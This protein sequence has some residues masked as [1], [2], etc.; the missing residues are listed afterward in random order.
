MQACFVILF[1]LYQLH[2]PWEHPLFIHHLESNVILPAIIQEKG[3]NEVESIGR[4]F[5]LERGQL[6]PLASGG[7]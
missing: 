4:V 7:R 2:E 3:N 5:L 6:M 1:P